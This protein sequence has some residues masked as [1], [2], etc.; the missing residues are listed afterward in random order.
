MPRH[1][2][3]VGVG[4]GAWIVDGDSRDHD[5]QHTSTAAEDTRFVALHEKFGASQRSNAFS[6]RNTGGAGRRSWTTVRHAC[7]LRSERGSHGCDLHGC[8][9]V[10]RRV[11]TCVESMRSLVQMTVE[12]SVFAPC[13]RAKL[14]RAS[15]RLR[16]P[17][18]CSC[19]AA[20]ASRSTD[21]V[22][23]EPPNELESVRRH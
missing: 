7:H 16:T 9:L 4:D 20:R 23:I 1:G 10:A 22:L 15:V 13:S 19:T 21:L 8:D 6:W 14:V 5:R 17:V 12:L 3:D 2:G 18:S 11:K